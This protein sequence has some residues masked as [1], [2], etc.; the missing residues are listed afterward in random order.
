MTFQ[1]S[2]L[3]VALIFTSCQLYGQSKKEQLLAMEQRNDSL[4]TLILSRQKELQ[5]LQQEQAQQ[6]E[7]KRKIDVASKQLSKDLTQV[8]EQ[9]AVKKSTEQASKESLALLKQLILTENPGSDSLGNFFV[10][11]ENVSYRNE[12]ITVLQYDK[13]KS[14]LTYV[15]G[16]LSEKAYDLS[17]WTY[18]NSDDIEFQKNKLKQ[19]CSCEVVLP[20]LYNIMKLSQVSIPEEIIQNG[21]IYTSE[22]TLYLD[23][24]ITFTMSFKSFDPGKP[25]NKSAYVFFLKTIQL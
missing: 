17:S 15:S 3:Y 20:T 11:I 23:T 7:L 22:G 19:A 1:K 21:V 5:L 25:K 12:Q 14:V 18:I 2:L 9:L 6:V 24:S 16:N 4:Q 10:P 13:E 8:E